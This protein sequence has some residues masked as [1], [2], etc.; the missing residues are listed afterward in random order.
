MARGDQYTPKEAIDGTEKFT[1]FSGEETHSNTLQ[2]VAD[3]A[4]DADEREALLGGGNTDFH[5]HTHNFQSGLNL[6][7]YKHLTA[8]QYANLTT[9]QQ[10][11]AWIGNASNE[12]QSI[13]SIDIYDV[14]STITNYL[15]T[16]S[17]W[18]SGGNPVNFITAP[19]GIRGQRWQN[20]DYLYECTQD[21]QW[22]RTMR[23]VAYVNIYDVALTEK[24]KL[25]TPDN[26]TGKVYTGTAI[27]GCLQ[28]QRHYSTDYYYEFIDLNTPIRLARA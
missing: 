5:K 25:E 6:G 9:L 19:G 18:F 1:I 3:L 8:A 14:S 13:N 12:P 28:G 27:T 22:I 2:E 23:K 26:W 10:N 15:N 20:A 24:V 16:D 7:D 17:N 4:L 21:L 11:F